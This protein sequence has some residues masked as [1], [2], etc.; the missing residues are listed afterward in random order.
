MQRMSVRR[1]KA[2]EQGKAARW[3]SGV[4]GHCNK[5]V[6]L[7]SCCALQ[8]FQRRSRYSQSAVVTV[9]AVSVC[10]RYYVYEI[11]NG[12]HAAVPAGW[13]LDSAGLGGPPRGTILRVTPQDDDNGSQGG[14]G[15]SPER[16]NEHRSGHVRPAGGR[17]QLRQASLSLVWCDV[18]SVHSAQRAEHT[19]TL[20]H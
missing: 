17:W 3:R 13:V 14:Q 2:A 16:T 20:L 9:V 18:P 1:S 12:G 4:A 11:T 8:A 10:I 5:P 19:H 6:G 15:A 7:A